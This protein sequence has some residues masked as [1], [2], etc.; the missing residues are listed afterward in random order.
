MTSPD[1]TLTG[2]DHVRMRYRFPRFFLTIVV[3][4][5][6]LRMTDMATG[7][8]HPKGTNVTSR[9]SPTGSRDVISGQ[10]APLSR[11]LRNFWV[12]SHPVAM[13]VM[14]NGTFVLLL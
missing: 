2:S 11:I 1:E 9:V 14:R 8:E 5:V 13:S 3:Q 12:T 7:C 4:N 10:K 6:P